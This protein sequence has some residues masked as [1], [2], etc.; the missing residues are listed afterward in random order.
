MQPNDDLTARF[1][2]P[3]DASGAHARDSACEFFNRQCV[4]ARCVWISVD[5]AWRQRGYCRL[6]QLFPVY[7]VLLDP[8]TAAR[9]LSLIIAGA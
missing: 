4:I 1:P 9:A 3:I 5:P 7:H 8:R 2:V 6:P